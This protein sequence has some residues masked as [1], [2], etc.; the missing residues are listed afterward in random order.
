MNL[1]PLIFLAAGA[2]MLAGLFVLLRPA[3]APPPATAVVPAPPA[4]APAAVAPTPVPLPWIEIVVTQ[5]RR[6]SGPEV[7]RLTQG[8]TLRLRVSSDQHDE[9]HLHGYDRALPLH[10]GQPA[11]LELLLDRSGRFEFELHHAHTDLGALE[12]LPR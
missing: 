8:D 7:I 10:P 5:G 6:V 12:V 9:L 2:A 11:E 3:P 1:R 4:A